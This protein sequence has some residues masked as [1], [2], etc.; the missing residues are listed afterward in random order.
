[1]VEFTEGEGGEGVE[2]CGG[3]AG[4]EVHLLLVLLRGVR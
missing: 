4:E 1:M 3:A 2:V